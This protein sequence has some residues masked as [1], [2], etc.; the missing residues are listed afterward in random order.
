MLSEPNPP[1]RAH[2]S[3]VARETI[4]V[5]VGDCQMMII[6]SLS[7]FTKPPGADLG[8]QAILAQWQ[9]WVTSTSI[10]IHGSWSSRKTRNP[11]FW[12][13]SEIIILTL[14]LEPMWFSN[15]FKVSKNHMIKLL[16]LICLCKEPKCQSMPVKYGTLFFFWYTDTVNMFLDI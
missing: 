16:Y 3:H 6:M 4:N 9:N 2:T 11:F 15:S 14:H 8:S 1:L 10:H 12:E 7:M 5:Q 13:V